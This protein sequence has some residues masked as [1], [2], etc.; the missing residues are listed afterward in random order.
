MENTYQDF[1][2]RAGNNVRS[3]YAKAILKAANKNHEEF[4]PFTYLV[5]QL[6]N[7][8]QI[9]TWVWSAVVLL[10][11]FLFTHWIKAL[12]KNEAL[13]GALHRLFMLLIA[14]TMLCPIYTGL[15]N[16]GQ[17]MQ[18]ITL[19]LGALTPTVGILSALGGNLTFAGTISNS[20]SVFLSLAQFVV[21]K[22]VPAVSSLFF[23]FAVIDIASGE[24]T[25]QP[26]SKHLRNLL[27][28]IFSI[29]TAIFFMLLGTK[30]IAAVNMDSVS[31]RTFRLLITNTIPIVGGAIGDALKLVGG[32]L[33]TIKNTLGFVS[34]LFL[35]S[36]YLPCI[37]TVIGNSL[38]FNLFGFL[39]EY[40]GIR[41]M[42]APVLHIKCAMDFNI[43][44]YT[45]IFAVSVIQ[46]GAFMRV[47]PAVIA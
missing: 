6:Q 16:A 31:A 36:L 45:F 34:V 32:G 33:V 20:F 1:I 35:L 37:L 39:C 19:F 14:T 40:F 27:F 18:D 8:F 44:S 5:P 7:A 30:N 24:T 26:L 23:G 46:I 42:Q 2:M 12:F 21:S 17:Y 22:I 28:V 3:E 47:L 43:A 38:L 11:L 15:Q 13:F 41:D 4:S 9:P 10:L 29:T 25:T